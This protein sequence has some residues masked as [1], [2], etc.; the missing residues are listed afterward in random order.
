M[1][2]FLRAYHNIFSFGLL[3]I[4]IR[5]YSRENSREFDI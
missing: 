1:I 2:K 5:E 3:E 4:F